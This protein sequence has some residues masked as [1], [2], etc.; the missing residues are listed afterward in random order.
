M[1]KTPL[2]NQPPRIA[3]WGPFLGA[4]LH[5]AV[6]CRVPLYGVCGVD[7]GLPSPGCPHGLQGCPRALLRHAQ[8]WV[9]STRWGRLNP[10]QP[11]APFC[12]SG[13]FFS[14]HGSAP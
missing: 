14:P 2:L 8:G 7:G 10:I 5:G 12:S 6:R 13:P 1:Y 4:S 11:P 9:G 3:S